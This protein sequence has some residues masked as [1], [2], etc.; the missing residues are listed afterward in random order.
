M[1]KSGQFF[2]FINTKDLFR[3]IKNKLINV[4]K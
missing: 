2:M 3:K 1:G 4:S